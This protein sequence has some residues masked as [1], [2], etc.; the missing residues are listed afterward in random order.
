MGL[1]KAI[2]KAF[3]FV[4]TQVSFSRQGSFPLDKSSLW[5]D[6]AE[7]E[8]YAKTARAYAGQP[9]TVVDETKDTVQ[10]FLV[11]KDGTLKEVGS[12]DS[13]AVLQ[14]E[15]KQHKVDYQA[16][17]TAHD[18][19]EKKVTELEKKHNKLDTDFKAHKHNA[20]AIEETTN[21]VFL[22]PAEKTKLQDIE[23]A[24]EEDIDTLF[25]ELHPEPPAPGA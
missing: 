6:K 5:W 8:A 15:L 16:L 11:K 3:K 21:R 12:M 13:I 4:E 17:K 1:L 14:E 24:T 19:L 2:N 9:I 7:A 18:N 10:L 22:S 20:D 25:P 23:Y